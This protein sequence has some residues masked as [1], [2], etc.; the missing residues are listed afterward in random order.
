MKQQEPLM[1][2]KL[3]TAVLDNFATSTV[4]RLL[5]IDLTKSIYSTNWNWFSSSGN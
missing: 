4:A 2:L 3:T 1:W 5:S